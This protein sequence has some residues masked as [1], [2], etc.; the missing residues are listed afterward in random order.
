ML[1]EPLAADLKEISGNPVLLFTGH[2]AGGAIASLLYAHIASV[3]YSPLSCATKAFSRIHCII[4]GCPPVSKYPLPY[5]RK[6]NSLF[7]N[8]LNEGDPITRADRG[9]LAKK[10]A[11]LRPHGHSTIEPSQSKS[12]LFLNSG[13]IVLL[14]KVKDQSSRLGSTIIQEIDNDGLERRNTLLLAAHTIAVYKERVNR[15]SSPVR[16]SE[17]R[18]AKRKAAIVIFSLLYI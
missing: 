2:S 3:R 1:L 17:R 9:F 15:L 5:P 10:C 4:F 12:R 13:T 8:F 7:L 14:R 18:D 11:W 6:I 16:F